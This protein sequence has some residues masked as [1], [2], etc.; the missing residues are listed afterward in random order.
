MDPTKHKQLSKAT[1]Q[2]QTGY[3]AGGNSCAMCG[4]DD[5]PGKLKQCYQCYCCKDCQR[6]AWPEHKGFCQ[7]V[8]LDFDREDTTAKLKILFS[9]SFW[10]AVSLLMQAGNEQLGRGLIH[11]ELSHTLPAYCDK[12]RTD[13][14]RSIELSYIP[15]GEKLPAI[16]E[17]ITRRESRCEL[18]HDFFGMQRYNSIPSG[19]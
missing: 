8:C 3:N 4:R 16:G 13:D 11:A 1:T 14:K 7:Q 9:R 19:R 17:D 6:A 10:G 5:M 18:A 12:T 2:T 15:K